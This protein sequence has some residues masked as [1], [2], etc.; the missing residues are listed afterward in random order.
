MRELQRRWEGAETFYRATNLSDGLMGL[1][2]A[3]EVALVVTEVARDNLTSR[4][5]QY[6]DDS[7]RS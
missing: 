1:R 4:G 2:N 3:V 7:V 5:C 6:R